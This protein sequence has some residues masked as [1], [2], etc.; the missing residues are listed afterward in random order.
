MYHRER[1]V[2]F[3]S[4]VFDTVA[5]DED[6]LLHKVLNEMDMR[7]KSFLPLKR[8]IYITVRKSQVE[9]YLHHD[10]MSKQ[11]TDVFFKS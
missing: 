11:N 10:T 1:I 6:R 2:R 8:N 7:N 5:S 9:N 4:L 3:I